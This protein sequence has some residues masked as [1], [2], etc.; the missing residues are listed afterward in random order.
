MKQNRKTKKKQDEGNDTK[1]AEE[2]FGNDLWINIIINK[3]P[4]PTINY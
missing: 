2:E 4:N 1:T 3:I